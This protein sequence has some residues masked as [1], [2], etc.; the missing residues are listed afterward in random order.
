MR[1]RAWIEDF[2]NAWQHEVGALKTPHW[3]V[4]LRLLDNLLNELTKFTLL[5]PPTDTGIL[6]K[7]CPTIE[8]L[9]NDMKNAERKGNLQLL[10]SRSGR[11]DGTSTNS[12]NNML[13]CIQSV[14]E[15]TYSSTEVIHFSTQ[16]ME[17]SPLVVRA[18]G[19]K[20]VPAHI[21]TESPILPKGFASSVVVPMSK[22]PSSTSLYK[23]V[24]SAGGGYTPI[25]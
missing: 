11:S 12:A 18:C 15:R 13:W 17:A 21:L 7:R 14:K 19:P 10:D 9:I 5:E 25:H 23:S 2:R 8:H 22:P 6:F 20:P 3:N 4:G 16:E 1:I 24:L